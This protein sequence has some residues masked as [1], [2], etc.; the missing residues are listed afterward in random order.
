MAGNADLI[1]AGVKAGGAGGTGL[2]WFA[3]HGTTAPTTATAALDAGFLDAGLITEDGLTRGVE[4]ESTDIPAYGLFV[5]ARTLVTS[6]KVTFSLAF[7]ETNPVSQ[8][9]YHRL[10]LDSADL[11]PDSNGAFDFTEGESRTIKYAGVFDIVDGDNHLRLVCPSLQ[12]TDR[13]EFQAA[14]GAAIT[15]GV[16]LTAFPASDGVAVHWYV[17][18]DA[19]AEAGS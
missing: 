16:T 1:L 12:V 5:P 8:A 17:V 11:I 19:L 13:T 18:A 14:A 6:S 7:L 15:Y 3:E 2:A 9:I 4:E 10:P